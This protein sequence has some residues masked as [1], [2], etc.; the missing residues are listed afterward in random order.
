MQL[1]CRWYSRRPLNEAEW[2]SCAE[3]TLAWII[4]TLHEHDP[5]IPLELF[6]S[7]THATA[8]AKDKI[9]NRGEE[10][11]I[12]PALMMNMDNIILNRI[13]FGVVK[14]LEEI[15]QS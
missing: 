8:E 12:S 7:P 4:G 13:A 14:E 6:P 9:N 3:S 10:F 1:P 11:V 2:Q 15:Y 5:G